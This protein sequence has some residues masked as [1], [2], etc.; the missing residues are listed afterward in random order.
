MKFIPV[1][2]LILGPAT[3]TACCSV[4]VI[5]E[6]IAGDAL[7]LDMYEAYRDGE[8]LLPR[9]DVALPL[10]LEKLQEL[11]NEMTSFQPNIRPSP[12]DVSSQLLQIS[13]EVTKN[14]AILNSYCSPGYFVTSV[15]LYSI[16]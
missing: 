8:E 1:S 11:I 14:I 2:S 9:V 13:H 3:V 6:G 15:E 5:K 4:I 16:D 10:G 7:G 12:Q